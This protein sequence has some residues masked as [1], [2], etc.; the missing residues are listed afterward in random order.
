MAFDPRYKDWKKT[1]EQFEVSDETTLIG[2]SCGGGFL[3]RYLSEHKDLKIR[4]LFLIAPWVVDTGEDLTSDLSFL[5]CELD[6]KFATRFPVHIFMSSDDDSVMQDSFKYLK[7]KVPNA[8][9][10]E[11]TDKKHFCIKEFPELLNLL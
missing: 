10:H 3:V 9:Y 8:V 4:S 11:F 7:E 5:K 6:E 1:F 2:H